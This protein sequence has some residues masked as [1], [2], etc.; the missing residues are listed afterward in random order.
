M[1]VVRLRTL[2]PSCG[3]EEE[4]W[5]QYGTI[6]P[7]IAVCPSCSYNYTSNNFVLSILTLHGNCSVS[8]H[9]FK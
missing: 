7:S 3:F 9:D 8:V 4:V 6:L 1:T 5:S 2:C